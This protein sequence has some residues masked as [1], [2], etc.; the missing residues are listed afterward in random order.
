SHLTNQELL[1]ELKKYNKN[2]DIHINNRKRLERRLN[3]YMN[4]KEETEKKGNNLLYDAVFIGLTTERKKLYDIIND[5]VDKMI[6][7][8]LIDEVKALHTKNIRSKSVMTGIGYKELYKYFDGEISLDEA[9]DLIKKNSRRYAKRQYTWFNHQMNI[10]W[11]DV[12]F[13]DFDKTVKEVISY[14]EKGL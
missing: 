5:R 6:A 3:I 9:I 4:K 1:D 2:I 14:I 11:F 8:G 12:N 7:A 13:N 10:T